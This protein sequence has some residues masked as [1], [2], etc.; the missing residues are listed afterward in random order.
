MSLVDVLATSV[1][2]HGARPAITDLAS[3]RTLDYAGVLAR[4]EAVAKDLAR[5]GVVAGQ[6]VALVAE[7]TLDHVPVAFGILASGACLV[8][9]APTLRAAEIATVL[10][11]IDVNAVVRL[12]DE[13]PAVEWIDRDRPAAPGFDATDAAFVRFTSGTT[14]EQKGVIL[15]HG[16]VLA[17]VVAADAVLALGPDDRVLWTLSLAYHFAVT[18]TAY[19]RAGAHVLLCADSLPGALVEA[20]ARERPTLLYGSP[21]QFARMAHAGRRPA[22][23]SVRTALS[24]TAALPSEVAAAFDAAFEV[25]LGQAYGIIEAGLPCIN[26]RA[27]GES[28][29]SVGRAV[30]GYAVAV[31]G[32]GGAALEPG[33]PGEVVVRGAGLFSGYYRPWRPRATLLRDGWFMTGD[34]GTL[35]GAGCLTLRGRTKSTIVVAGMKVFPEEVE[36]VLDRQ[37][38]VRES[39]VIGRAHPRLGEIPCAEVVAEAGAT[40]DPR[41]LGAACAEVLSSFK[42]PVEVRIVDAIPRTAAGKIRRA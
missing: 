34:V 28:A 4:A 10:A 19:L 11:E 2:R 40:L 33:A 39:R 8:P 37:P 42:V 16:D 13:T 38:G 29:A 23:E 31:L 15:G 22:L 24:T 20:C 41:A 26:T 3:G 9:I 21:I 12:R 32:P 27:N 30:P 1:A 6:R 36:A 35:D 25:P 18:I 5:A 14:A 7:N 17:R